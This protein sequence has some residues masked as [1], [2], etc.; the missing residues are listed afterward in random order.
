M[1]DTA[2]KKLDELVAKDPNALT[3]GD[4]VFL[5]ARKSYLTDEQVKSHLGSKPSDD[6]KETKEP[7]ETKEK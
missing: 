6:K 5:N 3:D 7:K 4:K 2:Q 1:N